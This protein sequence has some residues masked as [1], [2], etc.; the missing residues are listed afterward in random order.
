MCLL[1]LNAATPVHAS[2][3]NVGD[4]EI[5]MLPPYCLDADWSG[6][7]M[8]LERRKVWRARL[9]PS[10]DGLHHYCWALVLARRASTVTDKARRSFMY[11]EAVGDYMYAINNSAKDF[12]LL[13]E[14]L[15]R[16]G[17][18][19][20]GDGNVA[21]ALSAFEA[22]RQRKADYWP[23]Y[24]KAAELLDKMKLRSKAVELLREG[25]YFSPDQPALLERYKALGGSL[26]IPYA[27]AA[28]S[29]AAD[30]GAGQA[31]A[32]YA[33]PASEPVSR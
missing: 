11:N 1:L 20:A 19:Y 32:L 30:A 29:A 33:A 3:A 31:A 8:N 10:F 21:S 13:P 18:A 12:I 24:L 25:L 9:G 27:A 14:L 7:N 22:S 5:A 15:Y 4:G 23:A 28:A 26:P 16:M 6:R 2:P 17:E